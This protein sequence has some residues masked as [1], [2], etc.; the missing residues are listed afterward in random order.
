MTAG[1]ATP[2]DTWVSLVSVTGTDGDGVTVQAPDTLGSLMLEAVGAGRPPSQRTRD[3]ERIPPLPESPALGDE[4]DGDVIFAVVGG[5]P[6]AA[7]DARQVFA[8]GRWVD[9][10]AV[11]ANRMFVVDRAVW[12]G[13]GPVAARAVLEDIRKSINGIAPDG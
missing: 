13:A 2:S 8:S 9:L 12:E 11:G 3:G 7:E 6:G 1:A 10:D 4:L 5:A